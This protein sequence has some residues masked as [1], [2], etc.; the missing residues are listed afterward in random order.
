MLLELVLLSLELDRLLRLDVLGELE[1]E[2]DSLE[3]ALDELLVRLLELELDEADD[4]S[5]I[6]RM[7]RRSF[8]LGPGNWRLPVWKFSTSGSLTSPVDDVS[9]STACQIV[10]SASETDAVATA[11]TS[12]L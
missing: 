1:L 9:I 4:S 7:A 10:L 2:L 12:E 6:A 11:P 5:S 3:V 8:V